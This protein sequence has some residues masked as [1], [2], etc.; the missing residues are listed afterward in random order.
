MKYVLSEEAKRI[1]GIPLSEVKH[2]SPTSVMIEIETENAAFADDWNGEV[3][4]ILKAMAKDIE[5][6]GTKIKFQDSNGNSVATIK[7]DY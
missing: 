6:G 7:L 5:N 1:S 4:R 2:S 3:A